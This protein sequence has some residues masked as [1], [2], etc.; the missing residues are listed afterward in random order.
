MAVKMEAN[1][2]IT[3]DKCGAKIYKRF[4]NEFN[5]VFFDSE[6]DDLA[7]ENG[8][9]LDGDKAICEDCLEEKED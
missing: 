4:T 3:C 7:E 8:W 9:E 1:I 6:F 5:T 2:T